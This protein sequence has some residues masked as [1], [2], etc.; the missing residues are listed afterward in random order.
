MDSIWALIKNNR[1]DRIMHKLIHYI[2]KRIENRERWV[3]GIQKTTVP[4]INVTA[5][6]TS[7][8]IMLQ[9]E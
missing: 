8:A 4:V 2:P 1:G 5:A 3:G 7:A 6:K 9:N